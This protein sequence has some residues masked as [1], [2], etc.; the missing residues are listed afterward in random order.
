[1]EPEIVA[2]AEPS[3]ILPGRVLPVARAGQRVI[4][5][6]LAR[7]ETRPADAADLIS[8]RPV[9]TLEDEAEVRGLARLITERGY[10][11]DRDLTALVD[12][13]LTNE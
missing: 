10:H 6:L 9:L 8:L 2:G 11:R 7:V 4:L 13:Y 5:K 1:M 3:E 12:D